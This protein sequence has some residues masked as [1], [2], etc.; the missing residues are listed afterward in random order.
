ML[1]FLK[2][3]VTYI[4]ALCLNHFDLCFYRG[5]CS[6][7]WPLSCTSELFTLSNTAAS[8]LFGNVAMSF[9]TDLMC[10]VSGA[11]KVLLQRA[12]SPGSNYTPF[13]CSWQRSKAQWDGVQDTW[14]CH[15]SPSAKG[16][17]D[18]FT[19]PPARS[20]GAVAGTDSAFCHF[21]L[22]HGVCVLSG[23]IPLK[24]FS[25]YCRLN[26]G[27]ES[28]LLQGLGSEMEHNHLTIIL[29]IIVLLSHCISLCT[30]SCMGYDTPICLLL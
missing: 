30:A 17:C 25:R 14:Q 3:H 29:G 11:S 1:S 5:F 16:T 24:S 28:I 13:G 15:V 8:E 12:G 6:L 21:H 9:L 26:K 7:L 22:C 19:C 23:K 4:L 10:V 18:R 20:G 2:L 27:T